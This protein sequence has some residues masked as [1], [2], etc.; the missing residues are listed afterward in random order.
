MSGNFM[1]N[2]DTLTARNIADSYVAAY[3]SVHET[4][5]ECIVVNS[6]PFV[7]NGAER[8]RYWI[9]LEI[10]RLRQEGLMKAFDISRSANKPTN[11]L[12]KL[13]RRLSRI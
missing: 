7:V 9:V 1:L 8:D 11:N 4:K 12:F 13:I 6:K 2:D 3:Y 10:E 5:P